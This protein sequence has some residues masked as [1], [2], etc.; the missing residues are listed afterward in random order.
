M[1]KNEKQASADSGL[2]SMDLIPFQSV[3]SKAAKRQHKTEK[4]LSWEESYKGM[5]SNTTF[6]PPELRLFS[7]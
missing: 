6:H 1:Q 3:I 2:L 7:D 4:K 5:W